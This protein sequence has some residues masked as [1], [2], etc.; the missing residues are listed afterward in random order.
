MAVSSSPPIDWDQVTEEATD[1]LSRYLAIDTSNP[2]GREEVAARFLADIL[3][4]EGIEDIQFYDAGGEGRVSMSARLPGDGSRRP[5]ILLNHTDV[6]PAEPSAW[7]EP[8]FSGVVKEGVIWGRGALDMKSMGVMELMAALLMHRH[9]IP[10]RRDIVF[11]AVADEETGSEYGIEFLDRNHPQV[12]EAEYVLNEG[13]WGS[14]E[15]FGVRRPIFNCAVS[16]KGP[17]WLTLKTEGRAG[18]GSVP[19]GDN[20]L[21]RLVR[22][23]ARIEAWDRPTTI[24][25]EVELYFRRLHQGGILS[26]EPTPASIEEMAQ[27]NILVQAITRDTVS[28]TGCTAGYKHN[29]IPATAEATLDCRLL[30]GNDPQAFV[31][32]MKQVIDDPRVTVEQVFSSGT[33]TSSVQTELF[34]IVE[35]V[36]RDHIEEALVLPSVS[37]GF[38]DSRAFR[39]RGIT[40]YGL[41]P[42]LLEPLEAASIHG[43]N[44]RISV[45]NLRLGTQILFEVVRRLCA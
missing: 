35:E 32:Q 18:H 5:L 9:R 23:L 38:T 43:H 41:I 33:M 25:P 12:F 27:D 3:R 37:A 44:E 20:A 42:I 24:L 36:A 40:A 26:E 31:D 13:G 17:L 45:Q 19:H 6:V 14:T 29:V 15:V 16:E 39:R 21:E 7:E 2:P 30:P 1:I 4:R 34:G 10:R 8:P 22:A 11:L 28:I